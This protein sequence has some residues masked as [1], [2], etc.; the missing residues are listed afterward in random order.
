MSKLFSNHSNYIL[1]IYVSGRLKRYNDDDLMQNLSNFC[2]RK[3]SPAF[4]ED[5]A[6]RKISN[7]EM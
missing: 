5:I 7:N 2:R 6:D 1:V 3:Q 4:Q